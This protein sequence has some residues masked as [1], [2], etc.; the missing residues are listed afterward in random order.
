LVG[1]GDVD[2]KDRTGLFDERGG[3]IGV[4]GIDL[5]GGNGFAGAL[6]DGCGDRIA[7]R[8]TTLPTPPAPM[9]R[10]FFIS[11][12]GEVWDLNDGRIESYRG[13]IGKDF[14]VAI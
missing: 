2:Q 14:K 12:R 7:F 6:L 11:I 5:R 9:M 13:R 10:I 3:F 8:A 1:K 4:I